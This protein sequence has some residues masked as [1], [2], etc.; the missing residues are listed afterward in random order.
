MTRSHRV[1]GTTTRALAASGLAALLLG[2]GLIISATPAS[3]LNQPGTPAVAFQAAAPSLVAGGSATAL[4]GGVEAGDGPGAAVGSSRD[5]T[6]GALA[7]TLLGGAVL[8]RKRL[9]SSRTQPI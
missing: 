7:L 6:F 9:D 3:A 1:P 5:N 2:S 4:A 8:L